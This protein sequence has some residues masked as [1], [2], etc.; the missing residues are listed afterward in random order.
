V[1]RPETGTEQCC[2]AAMGPEHDAQGMGTEGLSRD[3]KYLIRHVTARLRKRNP[4]G[5]LFPGGL[6]T[7]TAASA[8]LFLLGERR[9]GGKSSPEPCLV[10]NKRSG[11]VRQPGDICFP[12]GRIAPRLDAFLSKVL[13]LPFF[14]L[15]R[16]PH[17]PEWRAVRPR[18]ARRLALLL[19]TSLRESLEEMRLNP[20]G[21]KF[22]GPLPAQNL[23]MFARV[24]YPM[25]GWIRG[26]ERFFPNWEVERIIYIPIRN[27]LNPDHY[28]CY[29][30][31]METGP[32]GVRH[33]K[34]QDFP[35][36]HHENGNGNEVLWGA[37]YRIVMVFLEIVFG[38][39]PPDVGELPVLY[40]SLNE[41]Y[42]NRGR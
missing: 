31:T 30:L 10:F 32:E 38:F 29:R 42:F 4:V 17:W 20:L 25:A 14:P 12:G 28:A 5:H 16:W 22:L 35:C 7:S 1:R 19:A 6:S 39:K 21:V 9:H 15:A 8:V 33:G 13:M 11:E 41:R 37:T 34:T 27:L 36:F 2:P 3:S 26:Q 23:R 18:E 24:I 40:G